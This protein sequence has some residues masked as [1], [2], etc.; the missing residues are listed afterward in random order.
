MLRWGPRPIPGRSSSSFS[1]SSSSSSSSF[2][3][4]T[5]SLRPPSSL[6]PPSP[7]RL[8][9]PYPLSPC[10]SGSYSTFSFFSF[11]SSSSFLPSLLRCAYMYI[12]GINSRSPRKNRGNVITTLSFAR[13]CLLDPP[14]LDFHVR[15]LTYSFYSRRSSLPV[16]GWLV[17][18]PLP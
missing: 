14:W 18:L 3:L 4:L 13:S 7:L 9:F 10:F 17:G 11:F 5:S 8:S 16:T 12:R 2:V 15:G 6:A 1:S